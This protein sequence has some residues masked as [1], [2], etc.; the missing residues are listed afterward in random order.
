M[1]RPRYTLISHSLCPYVQRAVIT[2]EE[3]GVEYERI[4]IDL[5]NKPEW[6]VKLSPLGR[7]PV[8][9][10]DDQLL[11]ESM[12]IT[13]YLNEVT[14]GDL[15]SQQALIKAQHRS[16]IEFGSALLADIGGLYNAPDKAAFLQK[17]LVIAARLQQLEHTLQSNRYFSGDQFLLV[18]AVYGT[19]FRYFDI[20]ETYLLTDIFAGFPK[21]TQ[22]RKTLAERPSVAQAVTP[23]YAD[24]LTVFLLKRGSYLSSLIAEQHCAGRQ[25]GVQ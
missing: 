25:L 4:D 10:V 6:F 8:L 22:W 13:E 2:L 15:H 16:W 21:L 11:F 14:P 12:V 18:D 9:M 23:D 7:V 17:T 5:A 19:V 1:N 24:Q 20:I 3:K